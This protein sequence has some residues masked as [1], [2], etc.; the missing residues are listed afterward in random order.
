MA[1]L[2]M[3]DAAKAAGVSRNTLY[4][5]IK[6][7]T[8]SVT[9]DRHENKVIDTSEL[10]RVFGEL[11]GVTWDDSNPLRHPQHQ[12]TPNNDTVNTWVDTTDGRV[13]EVL[14]A[15]ITDLQATIHRMQQET[16]L[17]QEREQRLLGL[18]ETKLLTDQREKPTKPKTKAKSKTKKGKKDRK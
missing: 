1:Q 2:N 17:S 15:Q 7:G 12:V 10:I 9:Y 8:I 13:I 6:K 11:Q 14:K 18:L 5:K 4:K 3:T 16:E